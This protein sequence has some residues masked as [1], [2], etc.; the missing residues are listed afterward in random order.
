MNSVL[1][2]RKLN[3]RE[4]RPQ[5][6]SRLNQQPENC[7]A[8][9]ITWIAG[10][11]SRLEIWRRLFFNYSDLY[12]CLLGVRIRELLISSSSNSVWMK[13]SSGLSTRS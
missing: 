2:F 6:V 4:K 10:W 7:D 12:S 1:V 8:R 11:S 3:Q 9:T 13:P 5:L